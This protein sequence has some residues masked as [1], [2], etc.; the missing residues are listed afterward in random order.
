MIRL[1][2]EL[3]R[4]G[5]HLLKAN[6]GDAVTK[7]IYIISTP[8]NNKHTH[9][10]PTTNISHTQWTIAS[11]VFLCLW[12]SGCRWQ[13]QWW[14]VMLFICFTLIIFSLRSN[15]HNRCAVKAGNVINSNNNT[16]NS[17]WGTMAIAALFPKKKGR[18]NRQ[19]K[20][21]I[22]MRTAQ[23]SCRLLLL[24]LLLSSSC[25]CHLWHCRLAIY[26]LACHCCFML[27]RA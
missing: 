12:G 8:N 20:E 5:F 10:F 7:P 19:A 18:V 1:W 14:G 23:L 25:C 17:K 9:G 11:A 4:E 6:H 15:C 13:W 26:W 3:A 16:N 22:K 2:E 27:F 24:F 21:V